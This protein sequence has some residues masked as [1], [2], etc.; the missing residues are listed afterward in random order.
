MLYHRPKSRMSLQKCVRRGKRT[1]GMSSTHAFHE[2]FKL[3]EIG[4]HVIF[5][6]YLFP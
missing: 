5:K 1:G 6:V 2:L 4:T 3:F